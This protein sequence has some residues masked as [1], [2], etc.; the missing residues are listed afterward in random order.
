MGPRVISLHQLLDLGFGRGSHLDTSKTRQRQGPT[1]SPD[2]FKFSFLITS[3]GS[4]PSAPTP[5]ESPS[6]PPFPPGL[7]FP[8]SSLP[9]PASSE[10]WPSVWP[11]APCRPSW[12]TYHMLPQTHKV[13]WTAAPGSSRTTGAATDLCPGVLDRTW[14]LLLPQRGRECGREPRG[15][16][17]TGAG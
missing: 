6:L 12:A 16:S 13:L 9:L 17:L 14:G 3:V 2:V 1:G 10:P 5:G 11:Q 15:W 7:V 4:S 8:L